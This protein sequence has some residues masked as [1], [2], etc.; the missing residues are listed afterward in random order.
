MI[1]MEAW[2]GQGPAALADW[3]VESQGISAPQQMGHDCAA[4]VKFSEVHQDPTPEN[5]HF[6]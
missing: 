3:F 5:M 6:T 4:G 1:A 2:F